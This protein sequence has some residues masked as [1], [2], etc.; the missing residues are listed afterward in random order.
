[1][2]AQCRPRCRRPCPGGCCH[3]HRCLQS[4]LLPPPLPLLPLP[5]LPPLPLLLPLLLLLL[6]LLP[7]PLPLLQALPLRRSTDDGQSTVD[8]P[9]NR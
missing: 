3:R 4:A 8:G 9:V 7:P 5:P 1:V 6:L 2:P